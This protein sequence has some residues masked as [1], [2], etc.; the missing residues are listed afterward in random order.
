MGVTSNRSRRRNSIFAAGTQTLFIW[1]RHLPTHF[2]PRPTPVEGF[3]S[4]SPA[5]SRALR[6]H[7]QRHEFLRRCTGIREKIAPAGG[8]KRAARAIADYA[9]R[10]IGQTDHP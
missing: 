7:V 1:Q 3:G 8:Y 6:F 5:S 4:Q 10:I 2:E 9:L